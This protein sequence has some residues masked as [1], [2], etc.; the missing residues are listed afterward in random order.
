MAKTIDEILGTAQSAAVPRADT[1]AVEAEL[2]AQLEA[3]KEQASAQV[4]Q[5]VAEN[6]AALHTAQKEA[7]EDFAVQRAQIGAASARRSTI[8]SPTPRRKTALR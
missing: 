6:V 4:D 1:S 3:A 8:P 2:K 5:S 7:E